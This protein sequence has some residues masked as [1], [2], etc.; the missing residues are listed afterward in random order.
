MLRR[1]RTLVCLS[2]VVTLASSASGCAVNAASDA[3]AGFERWRAVASAA[4]SSPVSARPG[5]LD[6]SWTAP[7]GRTIHLVVRLP[8]PR[9]DAPTVRVGP[10]PAAADATPLFEAALADVR[11]V[12]AGRLVIAPGT[13]VFRTLAAGGTAHLLIDDVSDLTID[14]TGA[15]LVF[16]RDAIG[17]A[18]ARAART[19]LEGVTIRYAMRT[20]SMGRIA[21]RPDGP[22]LVTDD[23]A[24]LT[25]QDQVSSVVEWRDG[26]FVH[27]GVRLMF[28]PGS[29]DRPVL[30]DGQ[31]Y[32]SARFGSIPD[33]TPVVV[34]HQWYGGV[35]IEAG[36]GRGADETE[37]VTVD[38][39]R[40]G[41]APGMGILAY[42]VRRGFAVTRSTIAPPG[43][44]AGPL[45]AEFDGIHVEASGGDIVLAGNVIAGTGDD[46][47]NL[48]APV[49]PVGGRNAG[50][51]V[52]G[53][54]SR[55]IA[56]GDPVAFF[57][58]DDRFL[59]TD[60]VASVTALGGLRHDVTFASGE[61]ALPDDGSMRDL[62]L[63]AS[64][65]LIEDNTIRD[66][67][68]HG[69]LVQDP[70]GLVQDNRFLSLDRNAIRLLTS[71]GIFKE[72]IGAFDVVVRGNTIENTGP[73]LVPRLPWAAI[74][75]YGVTPPLRLD[76]HL[77]D[78][79]LL[80]EG[81]RIADTD[82][83]CITVA[84]AENV[85][86]RRNSC[87]RTGRRHA[88][89]D[90]ILTLNARNVTRDDADR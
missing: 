82:D 54:W 62:A 50:G 27:G 36:S 5:D 18:I 56:P 11:R 59:G 71:A 76:D 29:P 42:G 80:I 37:D 48:N 65:F 67:N 2:S 21:R 88:G 58:A 14:G 9:A 69:L 55:F 60:R 10:C 31:L 26:S 86:L 72:G 1:L 25:R 84:D 90:Q 45:S 77:V 85:T 38:R 73:D 20:F 22:A 12:H 6:R 49:F 23:R 17:V 66:C 3:D 79:D 46:G 51:V 28:P 87:L 75:T 34:F 81:N 39:V 41:S 16:T 40:I 33:G 13:C 30:D 74:T 63:A 7:D 4:T 24:E 70:D 53:P 35:A 68:C 52:F 47:I 15:T 61:A 43:N 64:R 83:G 8:R 89:G 57:D 78:A 19:R 44:A 32:R